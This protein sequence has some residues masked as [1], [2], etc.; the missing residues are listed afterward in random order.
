[1]ANAATITEAPQGAEAPQAGTSKDGQVIAPNPFVRG[2]FQHVEPANID[3]SQVIDSST[4][5]LGPFDIP[6][7]GFLRSLLLVVEATGGD[8]GG[9]S[10]AMADDAPWNAIAE[11]K[12]NDVSGGQLVGPIS[13][14]DL[15]LLHKWL[16]S[17]GG[18][19]DPTRS[20]YYSAPD[21][22]GNFSFALRV[23]LEISDR[24]GLGSLANSNA[25]TAYKLSVTLANSSTIYATAPGTALPTVRLR[26]YGE[27]W[28]QPQPVDV[29]GRPN[30]PTPPALGST[31]FATKYVSPI[32]AGNNTI[33]LK[34]V[35]NLIRGLILVFRNDATPSVRDT[36]E[37]PEV[38]TFSIDSQPLYVIPSTMI[39]HYM[40]ERQASSTLDT[41]V[42]VIDFAHDFDGTIGG[43]MRDQWLRTTQAT[44][45]ELVGSFG[46]AGT[47]DVITQDVAPRGNYEV[48]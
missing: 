43:E 16:P 17:N 46:G 14:Y 15:F 4:H 23:P 29:L 36:A 38:I 45:L 22:N 6:S 39:R 31:M 33:Q 41:G 24:D 21:T 40:A 35:G 27:F 44:R 12:L 11:V 9:A 3:V 1:M 18:H 25:S 19:V 13:G 20:P 5:L 28:S 42:L 34:R 26:V 37:L 32:T 48:A 7:Y 2:S 10:V 8:K 30:S 47:L